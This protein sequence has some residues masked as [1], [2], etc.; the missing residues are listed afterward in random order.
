VRLGIADRSP[1][2]RVELSDETT[3]WKVCDEVY[4]VELERVLVRWS[5]EGWDVY[6]IL[7]CE[8]F[9]VVVFCRY[10]EAPNG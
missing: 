6:D 9:F 10:D 4:P 1:A 8:S 3:S 7:P 5:N 2:G